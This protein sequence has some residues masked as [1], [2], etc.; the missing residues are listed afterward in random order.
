VKVLPGVTIGKNSVIGT[1][2]VVA[3]DI[4]AGVIAVGNPCQ[5][6]KKIA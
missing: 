2:S 1:G 5:V 3:R 6:I 4:P